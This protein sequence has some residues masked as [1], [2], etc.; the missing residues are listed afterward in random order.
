MEIAK[1]LA[2][3]ERLNVFTQTKMCNLMLQG[4]H[5]SKNSRT[6]GILYKTNND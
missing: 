3:I 4:R 5:I 1:I 6:S 2:K